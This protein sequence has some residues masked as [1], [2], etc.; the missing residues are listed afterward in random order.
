V[1]SADPNE[2]AQ[3]DHPDVLQIIESGRIP[4]V[5]EHVATP[6]RQLE[7]TLSAYRA[8][9]TVRAVRYLVLDPSVGQTV[10]SAADA[11]GLSRFVHV[12][13]IRKR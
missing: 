4:I 1:P 2:P 10:Q 13:A 7:A 3:L 6:R 9:A 11:L 5:L 8:D 12:Q